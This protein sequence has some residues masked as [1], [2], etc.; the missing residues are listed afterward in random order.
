MTELEFYREWAI[1][2]YGKAIGIDTL[3]S[4]NNEEKVASLLKKMYEDSLNQ[5]YGARAPDVH[6]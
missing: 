1:W 2:A 3:A 5:K 4:Q 6:N